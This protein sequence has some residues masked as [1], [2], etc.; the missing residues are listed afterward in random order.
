MNFKIV[1]S[2]FLSRYAS[3]SKK[4]FISSM[5]AKHIRSI[6]GPSPVKAAIIVY[7]S[8][9]RLSER[10]LFCTPGDHARASSIRNTLSIP[11]LPT[12]DPAVTARNT[13]RVTIQTIVYFFVIVHAVM[14]SIEKKS[15]SPPHDAQSI[16]VS[17]PLP[18]IRVNRLL[19]HSESS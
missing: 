14:D 4:V 9:Y 1:T 2:R 8:G 5:S 6:K 11:G 7:I 3:L 15:L 18:F 13:C 17:H 12:P 10:A 19:G 16:S